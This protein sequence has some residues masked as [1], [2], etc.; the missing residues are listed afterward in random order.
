LGTDKVTIGGYFMKIFLILLFVSSNVFGSLPNGIDWYTGKVED[1]FKLSKKQNKPVF[2]YWGAA[3]CPPCNQIKK[4]IF[5]QTLFKN[6]I[7]NFIPVYLDGDEKRAQVWSDKLGT[8]GYPTMLAMNGNKQEI[9]RF[10][11]GLS[12]EKYVDLMKQTN[13]KIISIKDLLNLAKTTPEVVTS[14]QWSLLANYS[15]GQDTTFNFEDENKMNLFLEFSKNIPATLKLEQARFELIS[16]WT[17]LGIA[18]EKKLVSVKLRAKSFNLLTKV[19]SDKTLLISN[20]EDLMFNSSL[21]FK[22]LY[23]DPNAMNSKEDIS[24]LESIKTLWISKMDSIRKDKSLSLDE[25]MSSFAPEVYIHE[26]LN[27]D[28]KFSKN[29][30]RDI[31]KMAN[32]VSTNAHDS[33]S[34]QAVMSTVVWLLKKTKQYNSAK[35]YAVEEIKRS[36]SPFYFMSYVA[37]IEKEL[38]NKDSAV[39]WYKKAWA[40]SK[41]SATRFQWGTS[42]II[43]YLDLLNPKADLLKTDLTS[44]FTEINKEGDA[45]SGRNSKRL[46]RLKKALNKWKQKD[47]KKKE[48]SKVISSLDKSCDVAQKKAHCKKWVSS[49]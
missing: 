40:S 4:T 35:T 26:V 30:K 6:E 31:R 7:K 12:L 45:Y 10:P 43:A 32:Y 9:M 1:A 49:I 41:G 47:L 2:L 42:Y 3:W 33:Y 5:S 22:T 44:I 18:T 13:S 8:K 19:L 25:R 15:W 36:K 20:L 38:G 23:S 29:L 27:K 46:T 39:S 11:T 34:R 17:E 37:S 21:F 16:L 48:F 14:T 28:I 24:N